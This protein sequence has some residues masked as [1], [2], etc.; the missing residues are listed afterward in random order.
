MKIF[1]MVIMPL[2]TGGAA[3]KILKQ[4]GIRLPKG[5]A[6]FGASSGFG[7]QRSFERSPYAGSEGGFGDFG[8]GGGGMQMAMNIAKMFM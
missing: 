1:M 4:F 2:L 7:G 5:L 3:A 6:R 8:G